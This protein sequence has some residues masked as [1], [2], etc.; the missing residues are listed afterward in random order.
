MSNKPSEKNGKF[1]PSNDKTAAINDLKAGMSV[2]EVAA[3]H[4][5][6]ERTV[7]RYTKEVPGYKNTPSPPPA[8]LALPPAQENETNDSTQSN[9]ED[10]PN[11][12]EEEVEDMPDNHGPNGN[13]QE[14]LIEDGKNSQPS[15]PGTVQISESGLSITIIVPPVVLTMFDFAKAAKLEPEE[16]DL[17]GWLFDCVLKRYELDYKLQL[18]LL[19]VREG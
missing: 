5:I 1:P 13:G 6:S 10:N 4:K 12:K 14:K 11:L 9:D 2:R 3:K 19:P 15:P 7:F 8:Q 18:V 17:D 16:K